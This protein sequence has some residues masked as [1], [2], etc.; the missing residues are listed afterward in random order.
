MCCSR[1][2]SF[3]ALPPLCAR[4]SGALLLG[5]MLQER[6]LNMLCL[7]RREADALA[8]IEDSLQ[9][10]QAILEVAERGIATGATD[11]RARRFLQLGQR[12]AR[13]NTCLRS[14]TFLLI[15]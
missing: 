9:S 6:G 11:A 3:V 8:R 1:G 15:T 2:I 12:I 5:V 14:E 10:W 4:S 13:L 7:S